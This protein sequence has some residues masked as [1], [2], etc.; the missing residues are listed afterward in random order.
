MEVDSWNIKVPHRQWPHVVLQSGVKWQTSASASFSFLLPFILGTSS[1]LA[2][3][4][5]HISPKCPLS[6]FANS[7]FCCWEEKEGHN[8]M[9]LFSAAVS[10]TLQIN[11]T[12]HLAAVSFVCKRVISG[13]LLRL[14]SVLWLLTLL[15]LTDEHYA[16]HPSFSGN[17][18]VS[19]L[20][21]ELFRRGLWLNEP[22]NH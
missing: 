19:M 12:S 4:F 15:T 13:H 2:H 6:F 7:F 5:I 9:F 8:Q 17:L 21:R 14:T 20:I 16:L 22:W 10:S 1:L 3:Q 18:A 11:K